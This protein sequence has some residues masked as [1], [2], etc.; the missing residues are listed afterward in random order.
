MLFAASAQDDAALLSR[1]FRGGYSMIKRYSDHAANER[2]FLAWVRTAIAVMAFGFVIEKFDLFLQAA[3][4]QLAGRQVN[5]HG[6]AFA[7]VAGLAFIAIGVAMIVIAG[8]R[9]ARTAKDI[10]SDADVPSTGER[11]DLALSVLIGLLGVALF[12]YL[13]RAVIPAV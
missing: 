5:A 10:D 6:Q 9:F 8:F 2:T 7:N 13:S 1:G 11:F 4:P 3:V 12:L